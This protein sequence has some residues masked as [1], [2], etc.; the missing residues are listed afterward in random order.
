MRS[1]PATFVCLGSLL[2][3][4]EI[5]DEDV[6]EQRA[7]ELAKRFVIGVLEVHVPIFVGLEGE[8]KAM[9]ETFIALFFAYIRS[10]FER[11]DSGDFVL[12]RPEGLF[13]LLYIIRTGG[14]LEFEADDVVYFA[15]GLSVSRQAGD[16]QCEQNSE[17][18]FH[19]GR[20]LYQSLV[21]DKS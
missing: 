20:S 12:Q 9:R 8:H 10:P 17:K 1:Q 7:N 4:D 6:I 19:D 18:T 13:D 15:G 21:P 5:D 14:A 2:R 16:Q 11:L 3:W